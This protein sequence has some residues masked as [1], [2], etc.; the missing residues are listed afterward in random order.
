MTSSSLSLPP[1]TTATVPHDI[2]PTP[3][4]SP[5]TARESQVPRDLAAIAADIQAQKGKTAE[6]ILEIGRLLIEAKAQLTKH[7]TWLHWL[8]DNVGLS[9]RTAER[10]M[11]LARGYPNSSALANLS[12]TKALALLAIPD[13]EREAFI[14]EKHEIDGKIGTVHELSTR[15]VQQLVKAFTPCHITG[16]NVCPGSRARR[17]QDQLKTN[18]PLLKQYRRDLPSTGCTVSFPFQGNLRSA[19]DYLTNVNEFLQNPSD[20]DSY[21][22]FSEELQALTKAAALFI[23][24]MSCRGGDNHAH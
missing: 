21:I 9:T 24:L 14:A 16:N 8:S 19:Y 2:P 6:A 3:D 1:G 20:L 17:T 22:K 5:A 10:C 7:R 23:R 4:L 12:A 11:M 18:S 15:Q 13:C